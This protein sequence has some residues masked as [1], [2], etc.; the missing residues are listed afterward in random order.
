MPSEQFNQEPYRFHAGPLGPIEGLSV[1]HRSDSG[2]SLR[3]ILISQ[4][5][6]TFERVV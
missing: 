6:S 5:V 4:A 2:K 3:N 1:S